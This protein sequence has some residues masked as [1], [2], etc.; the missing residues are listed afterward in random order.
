MTT[1]WSEIKRKLDPAG[2][3]RVDEAKAGMVATEDAYRQ[4]YEDGLGD[5]KQLVAAV[6]DSRYWDRLPYAVRHAATAFIPTADDVRGILADH[7]AEI[8]RGERQIAAGESTPLAKLSHRWAVWNPQSKKWDPAPCELN[9]IIDDAI[10]D[11]T[12]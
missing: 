9:P 6:A 12:E 8:E 11:E 4:G 1:K 5:A 7:E 2:R 3:Q 10:W